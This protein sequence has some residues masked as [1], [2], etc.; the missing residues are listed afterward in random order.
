MAT[1]LVLS[2]GASQGSFEVG[3]LQYLYQSGFFADIICSTSVGSVNAV[4]LA[5][6]GTP[7]TQAAAFNTLKTIWETE[8]TFNEDMYVEAPWL[9]GVSGKTRAALGRLLSGSVNVPTLSVAMGF[10]PTETL[11]AIAEAAIEMGADLKNALDALGRATS[12]FTLAPTRTKINA[13]LDARLVGRS[14][15]ELRLVAVSLDGRGAIRYVTQSGQVIERDGTPVAGA[16]PTVCRAERNAYTAALTAST[17]AHHVLTEAIAHREGK[18]ELEEQ[19][20]YDDAAKATNDAKKALDDCLSAA[21]AAGT[22]SQ[23]TV[24]LVDGAIASSSIPCFF[25][26][27]MLGDEAYVDGGIRWTLPLLA[28]VDFDPELIVAVNTSTL[29]VPAADR[30]F[31]DANFIDIA[32]RS[33]LGLELGETLERH[34]HAARLQ[35]EDRKQKIWIVAPRLIVHEGWTVDPGLIDINIAYGFMCAADVMTAFPFPK[36]E[37]EVPELAG[38]GAGHRLP[39]G[40]GSLGPGWSEPSE[41]AARDAALFVEPATDQELAGKAESQEKLADAIARCRRECWE[42]EHEVFGQRICVDPFDPKVEHVA[43]PDPNA[44]IRLRTMKTLLGLLVEARKEKGWP[45]PPG[46]SGWADNWERHR[47]APGDVAGPFDTPWLGFAGAAGS[48]DSAT[49]PNALV[50]KTPDRD[51]VY[52]VNPLRHWITSPEALAPFGGFAVVTEIA[53]KY[54]DAIPRG[55]DIS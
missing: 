32:M 3:V 39:G 19:Q 23:L 27:T 55:P 22:A 16:N 34:L 30:T 53:A 28:A 35:A 7:P 5:H 12:M 36:L 47:F 15:V 20:A 8:L 43:V 50:A 21:V 33:V 46:A 11:A 25:P 54:L 1:A 38:V 42:I 51:E 17:Q 10:F 26:P 29:G 41:H 13:H 9:A 45:V 44:L 24:P 40:G 4:Q 49:R 31:R 48:L 18:G 52:L 37:A 6:G 14:G 2:G